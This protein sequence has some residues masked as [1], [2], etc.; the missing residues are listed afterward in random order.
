MVNV[1]NNFTNCQETGKKYNSKVMKRPVFLSIGDYDKT[2]WYQVSVARGRE[3]KQL[4]V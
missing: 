4:D 1:Q 3:V 2:D